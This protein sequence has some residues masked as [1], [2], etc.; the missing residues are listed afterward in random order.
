MN[1]KSFFSA[2]ILSLFFLTTQAQQFS[3][4]PFVGY[5]YNW[6]ETNDDAS[7]GH[8]GLNAGFKFTYSNLEHLGFSAAFAYSGEGY[9][10]QIEGLES[11]TN[12]HYLRIPLRFDYYFGNMDDHFRPKIYAGP[13]FGIL[14]KATSEFRSV[15]ADVTDSFKPFDVGLSVGTGF[16]YR[17][18]PS[19]WLNIDVNYTHGLVNINEGNADV[20][21]RGIGAS[22]GVAFGF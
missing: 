7:D 3:L 19:T 6:V 14:G 1:T 2:I 8:H 22:A 17:L 20:K 18:A 16:N 11:R 4:G 13:T 15:K 9:T 12:L 21:N 5:N 10:Q